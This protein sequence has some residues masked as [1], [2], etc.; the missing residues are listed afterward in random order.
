MLNQ[1]AVEALY[2]ATYV[3]NYLDSVEN[4]PLEAQRFITR[5]LDIDMQYQSHIRDID[6]FTDHLKTLQPTPENTPKRTKYLSR[7]QNALISAQELGDEKMQIVNQLQDLID[8]KTRQLDI[9]FKNLD[10]AE[11]MQQEPLP[12][13]ARSS[14]PTNSNG[15][16]SEFGAYGPST[17]HQRG[18]T[19]TSQNSE[20]NSSNGGGS[21]SSGS[22]SKNNKSSGQNSG[23]GGNSSNSK[24]KKKRKARQGREREE[25]PPPDHIDPDEPTYCL[26][27]QISFGEMIL[28]DNDLCPIEWFH[29]SCVQLV[30]KPKGKWFCP[31][32]RGDRVNMMKP[33]AQFLKEL[34]RYN[35]EREEKT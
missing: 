4:L 28:C 9:D 3:D 22:S 35:K 20:R 2:S 6:S 12:K 14:S 29:F 30:S 7:I 19:P 34:E 1:V 13:V 15:V 11:D 23:N 26:C 31:N 33:K 27:D 8:T 10:Y 32:C 24:Q 25:S 17:T 18:S 5:I 16:K 21:G